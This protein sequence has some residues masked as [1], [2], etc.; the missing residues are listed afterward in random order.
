MIVTGEDGEDFNAAF[1][2]TVT[3]RDCNLDLTED[4]CGPTALLPLLLALVMFFC[5]FAVDDTVTLG[6]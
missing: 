5:A 1:D 3:L 6:D 4:C 2:D